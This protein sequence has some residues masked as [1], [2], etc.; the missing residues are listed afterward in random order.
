[1][2]K[3]EMVRHEFPPGE[4]PTVLTA[5]IVLRLVTNCAGAERQPSKGMRQNRVL[6]LSLPS[7]NQGRFKLNL[8]LQTQPS[9]QLVLTQ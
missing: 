5:D 9:D 4:E 7:S 6:H 1:M 3:D 2:N 8:P